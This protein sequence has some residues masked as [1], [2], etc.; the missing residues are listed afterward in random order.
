MVTS[1]QQAFN[2]GFVQFAHPAFFPKVDVYVEKGSG[3]ETAVGLVLQDL[4]VGQVVDLPTAVFFTR[5]GDLNQEDI[6]NDAVLVWASMPCFRFAFTDNVGVDHFSLH[7]ATAVL[8]RLLA[9][10]QRPKS[11]C[12]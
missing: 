9:H 7:S 8:Q 5:D 6:T 1:D 3:I 11:V 2:V 12:P 10:L 4:S